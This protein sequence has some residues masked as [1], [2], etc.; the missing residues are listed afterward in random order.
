MPLKTKKL[1]YEGSKLTRRNYISVEDASILS[2]KILNKKFQ[3]KT[4][5]P[6]KEEIQLK[7]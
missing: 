2:V 5:D 4:F 1:L 6:E 7:Y 3:N